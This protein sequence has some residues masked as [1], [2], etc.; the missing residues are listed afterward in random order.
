MS[1]F[2]FAGYRRTDG[3]IGIRNHLLVLST[4]ALTNR[5]AE[6]SAASTPDVLLVATDFQRGL[7]GR[8]AQMQERVIRGLLSHPNTGGAVIFVHDTPARERFLQYAAALG[9]PVRVVAFMEGRGMADSVRRG[10]DAIAAVGREMA[11][12]PDAT[13]SLGD[14][15]LALE[16]GG[17]DPTSAVCANPAIGGLVDRVI[18]AGGRA[19]VSETAEFIG[20]EPVV[21][22]RASSP[23]V[24]QQVLQ[25]I[26]RCEQMMQ[27]DG[28]DYRGV[29]PT[30]EN[31]AGGLTTLIEKSMGAVAKCGTSP[32]AGC[33]DFAETPQ[34]P[35]LYFMDTP[36]FSPVSITGMVCAGAQLTLF[37]IGVFNPSGNPVAPTV[38]VCGN[39]QTLRDWPDAVDVD[40]SML[41][42]GKGMLPQ[43]VEQLGHQVQAI[44]NGEQSWTERWREGQVL[45]VRSLPAL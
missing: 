21:L 33:L 8:D 37:A 6:L 12:R 32:I 36:F 14:L 34:G 1:P 20:A 16:C 25:A 35:G 42:E 13:G 24:G 26:A 44:C 5:L 38:K 39:P 29:N 19:I 43:A 41:V 28:E 10:E 2:S 31:I 17:S 3:R 7:R 11:S 22:A 15:T 23:A 9:R 18:A 45:G 30:P 40:V 27:A 4:L